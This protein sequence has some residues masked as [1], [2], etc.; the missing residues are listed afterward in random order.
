[1]GRS[2]NRKVKRPIY[3]PESKQKLALVTTGKEWMD[4]DTYKE[5]IGLYHSYPNGAVYSEA[6][7]SERSRLLM[8]YAEQTEP[9]GLVDESGNEA[10]DAESINN[11]IYF[12]ITE[13]RFNRHRSPTFYYPTPT[14][15]EYEIG[16]MQRFFVR[17]KNEGGIVE[18]NI[19][20]FNA[21]NRKNE[22]G[23]DLGIYQR[24]KIQWSIAGAVDDARK[25]NLRVLQA[26][27]VRMPGITQY[28]SDLDEFHKN[29]H[30]IP[31]K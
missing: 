22:P 6:S 15:Q 9:T 4:A 26:A 23:I 8:P 28:L 19:S 2:A 12:Q 10:S 14:T 13:R 30:K 29:R 21:A 16:F 11:S 31:T 1:M 27:E 24:E 17:K 25:A 3:T 18:I 7:F 20:D 5:Y